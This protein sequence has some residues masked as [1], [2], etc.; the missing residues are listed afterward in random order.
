[1]ASF[2]CI[3]GHLTFTKTVMNREEII[4]TFKSI[5]SPVQLFELIDMLIILECVR[6]SQILV[7][8]SSVEESQVKSFDDFFTIPDVETLTFS[9]PP[10]SIDNIDC[11]YQ[12][13]TVYEAS[14]DA[15]TRLSLLYNSLKARYGSRSTAFEQQQM[16]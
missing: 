7:A 4:D 10:S 16:P 2:N 3:I 1:M 12:M 8:R 5:L 6:K 11:H 14:V 9:E 13:E 15:Y